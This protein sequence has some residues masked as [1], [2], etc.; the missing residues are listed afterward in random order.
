MSDAAARV[1]HDTG[2]LES[3]DG[4]RLFTQSWSTDH[5][6]SATVLVHGF[7]EHSTRHAEAAVELAR[8]GHAVH[9]FDLRG[10]GRS[11]GRRCFVRSF[12][13]HVDDVHACVESVRRSRPGVPL[14]LLGHSLGGLIAGLYAAD[15]RAELDG[16]ILSAPAVVLGSDYSRLKVMTTLVCGSVLPRMPTVRFRSSSISSDPKVVS[17][18]EVDPLVFHGRTPAR[19]ASSIVRSM[20]RLSES[21]GRIVVPLLILHGDSDRVAEIE[22]SRRLHGQVASEDRTLR[23]Y[24]GMWHE[25][26]HEPGQAIVMKEL[27]EWLGE[28]SPEQGVP[29]EEV[30]E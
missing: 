7:G 8:N 6:R 20:R 5:V 15:A 11:G 9:A 28:R 14:F 17:D 3:A 19:T 25:L 18:Y 12:N 26:M 1:V 10:H 22:G 16:L 30:S 27:L 29:T 23:I 24:D 13:E 4:L 2:A 21:A